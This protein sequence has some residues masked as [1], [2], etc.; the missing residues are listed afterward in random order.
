[1]A[2]NSKTKNTPLNSVDIKITD[3]LLICAITIVLSKTD[4]KLVTPPPKF[5]HLAE[6]EVMP[7]SSNI[8]TE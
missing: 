8:E 6:V 5:I 4:N 1:M 2:T 7:A 3:L